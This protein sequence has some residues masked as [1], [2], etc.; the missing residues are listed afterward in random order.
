MF[1]S[2]IQ[3]KKRGKTGEDN[4]KVTSMSKGLY[5]ILYEHTQ[6]RFPGLCF[7]TNP[8]VEQN[9]SHEEAVG[10]DAVDAQAVNSPVLKVIECEAPD[11]FCEE[12]MESSEGKEA[13]FMLPPAETAE[14]TPE[15]AFSAQQENSSDGSGTS[16]PPPQEQHPFLDMD[17]QRQQ[18]AWYKAQRHN[19]FCMKH[20]AEAQLDDRAR[21]ISI[22]LLLREGHIAQS[23]RV[24]K[25]HNGSLT[26]LDRLQLRKQFESLTASAERELEMFGSA[27]VL[28]HVSCMCMYNPQGPVKEYGDN[29]SERLRRHS[30][31]AHTL[32]ALK[33]QQACTGDDGLFLR[34]PVVHPVRSPY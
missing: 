30:V 15:E 3:K 1:E 16:S 32:Q 22:K 24:A 7:G 4:R 29:D 5:T 18:V 14:A 26:G 8:Q 31:Q 20:N 25:A 17:A 11:C 2:F 9:A 13:D 19:D 12:N 28:R 27:P 6:P 33:L 10:C 21:A 23:R 34:S